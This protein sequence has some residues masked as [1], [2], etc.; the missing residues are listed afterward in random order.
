MF[1]VR[2]EESITDGASKE[3][4]EYKSQHLVEQHEC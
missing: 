1:K 2:Q 3:Q 4:P